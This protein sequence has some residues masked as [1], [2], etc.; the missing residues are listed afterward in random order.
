MRLRVNKK[1]FPEVLEKLSWIGC[2]VSQSNGNWG[3]V[4]RRLNPKRGTIIEITSGRYKR[5]IQA[6]K[7]AV[8]DFGREIQQVQSLVPRVSVTDTS[9][10]VTQQRLTAYFDGQRID[11]FCNEL[12]AP[13]VNWAK[14]NPYQAYTPEQFKPRAAAYVLFQRP[15]LLEKKPVSPVHQAGVCAFSGNATSLQP[16]A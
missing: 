9:L 16:A 7:A 15:E 12:R 3:F 13:Q 2:I 11:E 10:S 5:Q 8:R 1:R 6:I 4:C 14:P